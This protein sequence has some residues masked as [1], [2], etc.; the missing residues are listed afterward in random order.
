VIVQDELLWGSAWLLWA[1]KNSSYLGYLYSLGESDSVDMFSW[2]NK[3]AGA[4]V[5]LSR[6]R[7]TAKPH[8]PST[9]SEHGQGS[10]T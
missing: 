8:W 10:N 5:L 3:L 7:N 2:D 4:R 6:V 9:V 1:T